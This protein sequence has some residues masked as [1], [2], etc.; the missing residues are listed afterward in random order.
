MSDIP[1]LPKKLKPNVLD[2]LPQ[3][4]KDLKNYNKVR[5]FIIQELASKHSH[6]EIMQW[7]ACPTCQRRFHE[8]GYVLKKLGFKSPAQYMMWSKVHAE[9][10]T[11]DPLAKYDE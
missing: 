4:L 6:S 7:A 2:G 8:R 9:I 1:E 11:R 5:K 10:R 3:Y